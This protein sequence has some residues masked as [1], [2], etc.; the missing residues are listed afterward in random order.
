MFQP[1]PGDGLLVVLLPDA[2]NA[3]LAGDLARLRTDF[4]GRGYLALT[5]R[6]RPGDAGRL[7]MLAEMAQVA[8]VPTIAT[9][10]GLYHV[11]ERRI[12]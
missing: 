5:L 2:P 10:D 7:R 1:D 3:A 4:P 8:R 9:G 6:R 12:L 11:P